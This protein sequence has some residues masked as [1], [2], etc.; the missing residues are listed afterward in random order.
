MRSMRVV[1][2]TTL[3]AVL[4]ATLIAAGWKTASFAA[5]TTP[6]T[7]VG[8]WLTFCLAAECFFLETPSGEG[9]VS[10]SSAANV[11]SIFLLPL[12]QALTVGALSVILTDLLVHRR[13]WTRA[14]FNAAQTT[15]SIAAS[16]F[17]LD[18]AI[19][20][21]AFRMNPIASLS[22]PVIFFVCNTVLVAGVIAL[23]SRARLWRSWRDNYGHGYN[24][25]SSA[26]LTI[27][28]LGFVI[29]I[30]SLGPI[31]GLLGLVPLFFVRDAYHRFVRERR[32]ALALRP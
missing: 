7:V 22:V 21:R 15:I 16:C 24:L 19:G 13:P 4:A 6:L 25:L 10:M 28:G 29:T 30:E 17:V 31:A 8:F 5:Q 9:M 20:S 3:V 14:I 1:C 32:W 12:P 11:A 26:V 27:L 2:Y 18:G 23:H